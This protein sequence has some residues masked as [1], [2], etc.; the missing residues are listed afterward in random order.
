LLS[1]TFNFPLESQAKSKDLGNE[2]GRTG[3]RGRQE[4]E[5]PQTRTRRAKAHEARRVSSSQ[6]NE[7]ALESRLNILGSAAAASSSTASA[8]LPLLLLLTCNEN[9]KYRKLTATHEDEASRTLN[10]AFD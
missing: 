4:E 7:P 2:L 6:F 8:L 9:E 3:G 1:I 10:E 5:E